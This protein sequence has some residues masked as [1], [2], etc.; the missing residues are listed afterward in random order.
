MIR[1]AVSCSEVQ[2]RT[3]GKIKGFANISFCIG[4]QGRQS[5]RAGIIIW[6]K[7]SSNGCKNVKHLSGLVHTM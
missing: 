7:T 5:N 1:G 3:M 2:T 4:E 6:W